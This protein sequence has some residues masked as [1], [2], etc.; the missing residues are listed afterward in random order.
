MKLILQIRI[1][2][3]WWGTSRLNEL[4]EAHFKQLLS[5]L[6]YNKDNVNVVINKMEDIELR[7]VAYNFL[8]L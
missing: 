2:G 8:C 3:E 4:S 1:W 7:G 6:D 5:Y